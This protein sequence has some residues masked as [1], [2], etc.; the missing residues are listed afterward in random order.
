MWPNI[1]MA[2]STHRVPITVALRATFIEL[3]TLPYDSRG[4][5][6]LNYPYIK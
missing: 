6:S 3:S 4:K 2:N 1:T 5:Y